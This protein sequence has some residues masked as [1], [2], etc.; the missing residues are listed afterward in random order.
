MGGKRTGMSL[1]ESVSRGSGWDEN[2]GLGRR[3]VTS[4]TGEVIAE[5]V[6][7]YGVVEVWMK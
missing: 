1:M 7:A 6:S 2:I 4:G 5:E 3:K